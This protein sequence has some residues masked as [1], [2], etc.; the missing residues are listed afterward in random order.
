MDVLGDREGSYG[1]V[2]HKW[3][4]NGADMV[5]TDNSFETVKEDDVKKIAQVEGIEE[6]NLITIATVVNPVNFSRIEDSDMDQSTDVG[7]VN[8]RGN[9]IMEMDMDVSAG[10][11]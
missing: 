1:G 10:K 9:R 5:V 4:E 8:L 3:L 2:T 6:Y 7:G 11:I